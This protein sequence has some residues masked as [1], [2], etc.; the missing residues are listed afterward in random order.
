MRLSLCLLGALP[1]CISLHATPIYDA[2]GFGSNATL[3]NFDDLTGGDCN[4]CGPS[5]T[6]QYASLGVTFNNPSF[7][8]Q[9]TADTN[10]TSLI[11]GAS[12]PNA[13]YVDQGGQVNEPAAAPFQ[14]LFS[15]PVTMVGFD[16]GSS[17]DSYL[18]LDVYSGTTLL[19]TDD[20][21]GT[22]APIG[23]AGFAG[24]EESTPITEVDVSYHPNSDPSQTYSFSMD[25]LEFQ[26]NS[27]PEPS[28][29]GMLALGS[30]GIALGRWR[31]TRSQ[32][33]PPRLFPVP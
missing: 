30:L 11:T 20:F 32:P 19:E 10:L 23:L 15:T 12:L 24:V 26:G 5:V 28:T 14:I 17:T 7:P 25:N 27:V 8:G 22:S 3:I 9:D 1:W 18:E 2:S 29:L 6:T 4:L 21:T 13:L 31:R 33:A 16:F